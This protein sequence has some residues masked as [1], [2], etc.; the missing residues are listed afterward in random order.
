MS[1]AALKTFLE[2]ETDDCRFPV[3]EAPLPGERTGS[4]TLFC[5]APIFDRGATLRPYCE[6]HAALASWRGA[7]PHAAFARVALAIAA[8]DGRQITLT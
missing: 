4:A 6:E 3:G 1:G 5:G 7:M 8:R 2:L